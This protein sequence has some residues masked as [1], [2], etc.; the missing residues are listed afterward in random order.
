[1]LTVTAEEQQH[2][3]MILIALRDIVSA[4][5]ATLLNNR[6]LKKRGNDNDVEEVYSKTIQCIN[7]ENSKTAEAGDKMTLVI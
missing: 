7:K 4:A 2:I 6:P 1:M 5:A 3:A